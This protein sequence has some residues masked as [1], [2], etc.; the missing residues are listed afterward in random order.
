MAH[1]LGYAS[2]RQLTEQLGSSEVTELLAYFSLVPFGDER[3]DLRIGYAFALQTNALRTNKKQKIWKTADFVFPCWEAAEK[4]VFSEGEES[5]GGMS[6]DEM[7]Q[8]ATRM[9][10]SYKIASEGIPSKK[11]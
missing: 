6:D 8:E 1:E 2:I 4:A 11:K 7:L 10:A 9:V 3:A 5:D